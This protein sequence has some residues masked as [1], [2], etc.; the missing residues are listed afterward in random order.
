MRQQIET[1][2]PGEQRQEVIGDATLSWDYDNRKLHQK[3]IVYPEGRC[4]FH[5]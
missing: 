3:I 5:R 1:W 2:I 4:R